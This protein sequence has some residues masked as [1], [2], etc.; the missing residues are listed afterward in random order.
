MIMW[1]RCWFLSSKKKERKEESF[2]K[3]SSVKKRRKIKAF[4]KGLL[5]VSNERIDEFKLSSFF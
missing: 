3:K 1:S 2:L 5:C 4:A